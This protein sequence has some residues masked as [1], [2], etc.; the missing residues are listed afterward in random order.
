[1]DSHSLLRPWFRAVSVVTASGNVTMTT[2]GVLILNKAS[3]AATAVTLPAI[4]EPGYGVIIKDGKGDAATNPITISPATGTI[5]GAASVTIGENYGALWFQHNGTEWNIITSNV[6]STGGAGA[7]VTADGLSVLELGDGAVH[8]TVL[9]FDGYSLATTD[10]GT[11]GHG[12]G[13]KVY[14]FPQGL[15]AITGASQNW[16]TITVDGTGLPNDVDFDIGVGTTVAT[17]AMASL[18]GTTVDIVS[19]DDLTMSTSLS[20]VNQFQGT[21]SAGAYIDGSATAKDAYL[22]VSATVATADG[23]GTLTLTGTVIV[24]WANVGVQSS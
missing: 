14:D 12:G 24:T 21:V 6:S 4:T 9:L 18:T 15:I 20:A 17:S 23:D 22:N 11:G 7:V 8:K 10:N 1:M 16:E 13:A 3:G 2:E 19:K 5:D